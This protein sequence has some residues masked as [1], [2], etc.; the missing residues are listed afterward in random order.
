[1]A[2]GYVMR[3]EKQLFHN[4]FLPRTGKLNYVAIS[5]NETE[6]SNQKRQ[7]LISNRAYLSDA[8]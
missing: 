4:K 2:D 6:R 3:F 5:K 8:A 7:T 1:M